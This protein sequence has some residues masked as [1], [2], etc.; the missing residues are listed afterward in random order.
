MNL[1]FFCL[2]ALSLT[3]FVNIAFSQ[4]KGK[5]ITKVYPVADLVIPISISNGKQSAPDGS[6]L[7][8]DLTKL[9]ENTVHSSSWSNS[10]GPGTVEYFPTGNALVVHQSTAVQEEIAGLLE[11]LRKLQDRQVYCEIRVLSVPE[12]AYSEFVKGSYCDKNQSSSFANHWLLH[13]C[14]YL[15]EKEV[16]S[17]FR[18]MKQ[19]ERMNCLT[20]PKMAMFD[21]QKGLVCVGDDKESIKFSVVPRLSADQQFIAVNFQMSMKGLEEET[22]ACLRDNTWWVFGGWEVD[23]KMKEVPNTSKIP[24]INRLFKNPLG[25][26]RILVMLKANRLNVEEKCVTPNSDCGVGCALGALVGNP[27]KACVGSPMHPCM[28]DS[29]KTIRVQVQTAPMGSL[30]LGGG[31]NSDAGVTGS[32][33][34][35]ERNFNIGLN[36][37]SDSCQVTQAKSCCA[38]ELVKMEPVKVL[39][40]EVAD[41]TKADVDLSNILQY[42]SMQEMPSKMTAKEIIWLKKQNVH[43]AVIERLM[44]CP[45]TAKQSTTKLMTGEEAASVPVP[46]IVPTYFPVPTTPFITPPAPSRFTWRACPDPKVLR[47]LER[48]YDACQEG[49]L[50]RAKKYQKTL[51][52]YFPEGDLPT[53][54]DY[55]TGNLDPSCPRVEKL[56]SESPVPPP[57]RFWIKTADGLI[58]E[59]MEFK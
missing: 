49:D 35:N 9:I 20:A 26:E 28:D 22:T 23:K 27:S 11:A 47:L 48:Y 42:V 21:G 24:Y 55:E 52:E 13:R 40:Q 58:R 3:G 25:K 50:D 34:L 36:G 17:L 32:I 2:I 54:E 1:R 6:K 56:M 53:V 18:T 37:H 10:G 59:G 19:S 8:S 43:T 31:V 38:V 14:A 4:E 33:I 30:P 39:V 7:A 15:Q 44:T 46:P 5:L 16:H 12:E 51:R 45:V 29:F 57:T 41:M